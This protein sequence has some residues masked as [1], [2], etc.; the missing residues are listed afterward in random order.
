MADIAGALGVADPSGGLYD[1]GVG[2]GAP[3]S[4]SELGMYEHD[5]DRAAGLVL[6]DPGYN[7]RPVEGRWIRQLL[8]DAFM[9]RKPVAG[10]YTR[11]AS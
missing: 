3:S 10:P 7:P 1:M 5:L 6:E 9:G 11:R 2:A 8:G 4:L